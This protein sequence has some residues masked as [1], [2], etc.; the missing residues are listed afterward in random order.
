[1]SSA[2]FVTFQIPI[3]ISAKLKDEKTLGSIEL[4]GW[5]PNPNPRS[6]DS[7]ESFQGRDNTISSPQCNSKKTFLFL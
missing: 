2:N 4:Q 3:I 1:M 5:R 7:A 6:S